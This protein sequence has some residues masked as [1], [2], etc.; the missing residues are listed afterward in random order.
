AAEAVLNEVARKRA[1]EAGAQEVRLVVSRG[2]DEVG[3]SGRQMFIEARIRVTASG[4]PRIAGAV[5]GEVGQGM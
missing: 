4:R 2:V 3:V 1:R 5:A